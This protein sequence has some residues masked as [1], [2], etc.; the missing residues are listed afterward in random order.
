MLK[1][2]NSERLQVAIGE[3][4][5]C[6]TRELS[7]SFNVSRHMTICREMKRLK[8]WK[9]AHSLSPPPHDLSEIN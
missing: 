4:P 3:N 6:T 1:K 7:K 9:R 5:T 8:G 2:L